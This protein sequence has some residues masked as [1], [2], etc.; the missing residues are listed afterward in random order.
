M[1]VETGCPFEFFFFFNFKSYLYILDNRPLSDTKFARVFHSMGCLFTSV[2][3]PTDAQIF[4]ILV[5]S[6]LSFSSVACAFGVISKNPLPDLEVMK[7]YPFDF[8]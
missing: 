5:K 8:F 1:S 6:N 4:L 7:I 3:M 2:L